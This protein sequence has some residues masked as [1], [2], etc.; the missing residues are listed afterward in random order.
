MSAKCCPKPNII[1]F[2]DGTGLCQTCRTEF[3]AGVIKES[4]TPAEDVVAALETRITA[5]EDVLSRTVQ[6]VDELKGAVN[7]VENRVLDLEGK[8]VAPSDQ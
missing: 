8:V 3:E 7:S 2:P 5:L 6:S 4:T 1:T